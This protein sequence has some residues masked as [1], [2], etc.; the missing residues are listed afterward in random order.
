M[1]K[2]NTDKF[3]SD[4]P[5]VF[6]KGFRFECGDG[7]FQPLYDLAKRIDPV[8]D[9]LPQNAQDWFCASQIKEKFGTLR[10]SFNCSPGH[11][12]FDKNIQALARYTEYECM[13]ICE[14]CGKEGKL[15]KDIGWVRTLCDEHH[16]EAI[17]KRLTAN[18]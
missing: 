3:I 4:F 11:T 13:S 7:W 2:E 10:I 15:R 12:E 5:R 9:K 8:L 14:K 18:K 6:P 17:E 1:N 16:K